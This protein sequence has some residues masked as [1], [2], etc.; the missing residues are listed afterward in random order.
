MIELFFGA[1]AGA[2][3]GVWFDIVGVIVFLKLWK[4]PGSWVARIW[5]DRPG[6][7]LTSPIL[8]FHSL[9]TLLGMVTGLLLGLLSKGITGPN[10]PFIWGIVVVSA[11]AGVVAMQR[12]GPLRWWLFSFVLVFFGA[13]GV[14]L[15]LWSAAIH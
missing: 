5:G 8:F 15:P 14:L 12:G 2:V 10:Q 7:M 1:I 4:V 9:W 11:V 13:F 6:I 3:V